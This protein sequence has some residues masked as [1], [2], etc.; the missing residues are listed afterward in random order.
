MKKHHNTNE[1]ELSNPTRQEQENNYNCKKTD[2]K[3]SKMEFKHVKNEL[4]KINTKLKSEPMSNKI[5][6]KVFNIFQLLTLDNLQKAKKTYL[7][8]ILEQLYLLLDTEC[9]HFFK[10]NLYNTLF[11]FFLKSFKIDVGIKIRIIK[12]I[13]KVASLEE[14]FCD[15]YND[16]NKLDIQELPD[17][18]NI[19]FR[20]FILQKIL[21]YIIK[22]DNYIITL[23]NIIPIINNNPNCLF[24]NYIISRFHKKRNLT[25]IFYYIYNWLFCIKIDLNNI[26]E[27]KEVETINEG[28][29]GK[30]FDVFNSIYQYTMKKSYS[31][32]KKIFDLFKCNNLEQIIFSNYQ[33]LVNY[34]IFKNKKKLLNHKIIKVFDRIQQHNLYNKLKEYPDIFINVFKQINPQYL[35][36]NFEKTKN[37]ELLHV[38]IKNNIINNEKNLIKI[39]TLLLYQIEA[40]SNIEP[41]S[42]FAD[43]INIT[44]FSVAF[45]TIDEY[46]K[47]EIRNKLKEFFKNSQ[48]DI[49]IDDKDIIAK[50]HLIYHTNIK[51]DM[52]ELISFILDNPE[53]MRSRSKYEV[54]KYILEIISFNLNVLESNAI[55]E[56]LLKRLIPIIKINLRYKE[57]I[58]SVG[59]IFYKIYSL[60]SNQFD[61]KLDD[62]NLFNRVVYGATNN[63]HFELL[64]DPTIIEDLYGLVFYIRFVNITFALD[65]IKYILDSNDTILIQLLL[66]SIIELIHSLDDSKIHRLLSKNINKLIS[67]FR[68]YSK[69]ISIILLYCIKKQLVIPQDVIKLVLLEYNIYYLYR[70]YYDICYNSINDCITIQYDSIKSSIDNYNTTIS[71]NKLEQFIIQYT[72]NPIISNLYKYKKIKEAKLIDILIIKENK[73]WIIIFLRNIRLIEKNIC[74]KIIEQM[75]KKI[76]DET[77]KDILEKGKKMYQM[78]NNFDLQKLLE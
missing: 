56:A 9:N 18:K 53:W 78:K 25:F 47:Y 30:I 32:D 39:Y 5:Q 46:I 43:Y 4:I 57:H 55:N 11:Y 58:K 34:Y 76:I 26:K 13:L 22:S 7:V 54:V 38:L 42:E 67:L 49:K 3:M 6:N 51:T 28:I 20:N 65:K 29:I 37:L 2:I 8:N 15:L 33:R 12:H 68:N 70:N 61:L 17:H 69:H 72:I 24:N 71:I 23:E 52:V 75:Q 50:L 77:I 60:Y 19:N 16:Y 64:F 21:D 10:Q 35:L 1:S 74:K 48:I 44:I 45:L 66:E 41:F 73:L 40:H 27:F 31:V 59:Q 62:H 14:L 63:K 36:L